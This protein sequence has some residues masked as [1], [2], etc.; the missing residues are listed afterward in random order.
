MMRDLL[1]AKVMGSA[2]SLL[3]QCGLEVLGFQLRW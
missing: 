2:R 1:I 3:R